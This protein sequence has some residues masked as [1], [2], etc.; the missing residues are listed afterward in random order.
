MRGTPLALALIAWAVAPALAHLVPVP[1]SHCAFDPIALRVPATGVSGTAQPA[2]PADAMRIIYDPGASAI[3]VCPALDGPVPCGPAV[4]RAFTLGTATGTIAFPLLFPGHMMSSGDV[5]FAQLPVTFTVGADVVTSPVTFTTGLATV[6]GA[7]AEG[8]PLQGL[9]QVTLVGVVAGDALP[10]AIAGHALVVTM[11]C[12]PL[13]VPD[14][15]QFEL[16]PSVSGIKGDI[17]TSEARLQ[18]TI[19]LAPSPTPPDFAGRPTMLVVHAD[20][21]PIASALVSAGLQGTRRISGTS[22][23]GHTTIDVRMTSPTKLLV[24]MRIGATS[25]PAQSAGARALIDVTLE[26]GGVLARGE[27]LFQASGGGKLTP[28]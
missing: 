25:L 11:S 12:Q 2:G 5:T 15:D 6:E 20:G 10:A 17:T 3:Q 8:T 16:A 18:A 19:A 13:P 4:P 26:T 27:Q 7:V 28:H 14:K 24:D 23:D 21:T 1:P 22:D 9:Q